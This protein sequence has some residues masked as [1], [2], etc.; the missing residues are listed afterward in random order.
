MNPRGWAAL[1][2]VVVALLGPC[3]FAAVVVA[4]PKRWLSAAIGLLV[5]VVA[6]VIFDAG[7]RHFKGTTW[8]PVLLVAS[9]WICIGSAIATSV[10]WN[11]LSL[12]LGH[13]GVLG[14]M[15]MTNVRQILPRDDAE[16]PRFS[17]A[18]IYVAVLV[19]LFMLVSILPRSPNHLMW[20]G[21]PAAFGVAT[22]WLVS[23]AALSVSN[24]VRTRRSA[25]RD[26]RG[27]P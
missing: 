19:C 16:P 18:A 1:H 5:Q 27:D 17:R 22:W 25:G 3:A 8:Y 20:L 13:L 24:N 14:A 7:A 9:G 21:F 11:S 6:Y 10:R 26:A 4:D 23:R 12:L 2:L 15:A